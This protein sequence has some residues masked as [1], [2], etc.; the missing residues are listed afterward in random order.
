M[1]ENNFHVSLSKWARTIGEGSKVR[2][3][4]LMTHYI[5][6]EQNIR[7]TMLY[8]IINEIT[9]IPKKE[10]LILTNSRTR[11]KHR[12][13]FRIMIKNTNEYKYSFF[14]RNICK[15]N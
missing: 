14:P 8:K 4:Q 9:N 10:I 7:L 13:T 2:Q 12:H 6:N 3:K 11:S 15:K 1:P 5:A